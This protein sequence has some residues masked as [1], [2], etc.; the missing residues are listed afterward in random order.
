MP[1]SSIRTICPTFPPGTY[2]MFSMSWRRN[3]LVL[4]QNR[5]FVWFRN[6]QQAPVVVS[7]AQCTT[8]PS[9]TVAPVPICPLVKQCSDGTTVNILVCSS[10]TQ[11]L[12]LFQARLFRTVHY[13]A[14]L[15][16]MCNTRFELYLN[17]DSEAWRTLLSTSRGPYSMLCCAWKHCSPLPPFSIPFSTLLNNWIDDP[18]K[19]GD[20]EYEPC[21]AAV[22]SAPQPSASDASGPSTLSTWVAAAAAVV[23]FSAI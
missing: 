18:Q 15:C 5:S 9:C 20:C 2:N 21:A 7:D 12:F 16:S 17:V 1:K 22:A 10:Q 13:W 23:I 19:L 4:V 14:T 8:Q 3:R 6:I 11:H